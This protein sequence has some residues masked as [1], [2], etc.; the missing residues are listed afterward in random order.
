MIRVR[1]G[2]PDGFVVG[3]EMAIGQW[4][5]SDERFAAYMDDF[6]LPDGFVTLGGTVAVTAD[7]RSAD[8]FDRAETF[9]YVAEK[10]LEEEYG[11]ILAPFVVEMVGVEYPHDP[12]LPPDTVF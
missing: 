6:T 1:V 9:R 3:A 8:P 11:P 7:W 4:V 2:V 5:V 12:S 10:W